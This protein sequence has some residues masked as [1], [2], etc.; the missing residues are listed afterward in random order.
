MFRFIQSR[1]FFQ[2]VAL[3]AVLVWAVVQMVTSTHY[4]SVPAPALCWQSFAPLGNHYVAMCLILA[5]GILLQLV[6]T[7]VYYF[8]GG[9]GDSHHLMVVFWYMLLLCCGGFVSD[10]SPVMLS[11]IVLAVV[12]TLSFD[13]D[14]GN[15]KSKD[16]LLGMIIGIST[17]FYPPIVLMAL[18]VVSSLIVNKF[19][20][21]K[22]IIVFFLGILLVYIYVFCFYFFTNRLT[23]LYQILSELRWYNTIGMTSVFTWREIVLVSAL[24]LSLLYSLLILKIEYNNKQI[25]LRKRLITIHLITICVLLMFFFSPFDIHQATGFLILPMTLYYAML[26]QIK[27][28]ALV[29]DMVMLIFAVALCL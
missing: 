26:S 29:N 10:F 2:S 21:Y 23:E 20:K 25:F 16:L 17:L 3:L 19:S 24:G 14:N 18:F 6:L 4:V 11:N 13:Y 28:H 8:R 7:D 12:I 9:F 5:F 1:M 22:D 27:Q 15:L